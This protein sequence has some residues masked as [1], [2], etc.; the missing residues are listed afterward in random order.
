MSSDALSRDAACFRQAHIANREGRL[1]DAIESLQQA[2]AQAPTNAE[3][4]YTLGRLRKSKGDLEAAEQC[5]REAVRV[6]PE[7]VD[8]W[9][10][11]GILLR[12]AGRPAE[13]EACQREALRIDPKNSLAV[14]NLGNAL[15]SQSKFSDAAEVLRESQGR[16]D[17]A[18]ECF[19]RVIESNPRS[20]EAHNNLGRALLSS[21]EREAAGHFRTALQLDPKLFDAAES[22]GKCQFQIGAFEESVQAFEIAHR[23]R[24][25]SLEIRLLLANAYRAAQMLDKAV[26]EY[27]A[28]LREKPDL[29]KAKGGLATTLADRGQYTKPRALFEQVLADGIEDHLLRLNYAF[30]LLR[31]GDFSN[32]WKYYESRWHAAGKGAEALERGLPVPRWQGEPLTGKRLVMT[33]EQGLGDEMMFASVLP[34]IVAEAEHCIV[35]CDRR[36]E[37]LFRRSFPRATV[38]GVERKGKQWNRALEQNLHALPSFDYWS[39]AGTLVAH[40]RRSAEHFPKH[41]GYLR[42]DAG[43]VQQWKDR[44]STLG[45][46]LKVGISWRGGTALTRIGA[47]SMSLE[48]LRPVLAVSNV[49]FVN[50]QY[51][52]C[53]EDLNAHSAAGGVPIHHWQDAHDDYDETAALVTAL[54]V[55]ISVCTAVV[56]LAGALGRPVWVMAPAV[57]EWRYGHEGPAMIWYP[58]ARIFRQPKQNAWAPVVS[59][60]KR[61]LNGMAARDGR[62]QG[63]GK[64]ENVSLTRFDTRT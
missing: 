52:D 6:R 8:A 5:Y 35:E 17:E 54:D 22:L 41:G 40:R 39:P 21:S 38:F 13:A 30:F 55:V 18:A 3:Y 60:V 10:S 46:G 49:H 45:P 16:F 56:H 31:N 26:A 50:L 34:E 7:Y 59:E 19:R 9:I 51:G 37:S 23:L 32:A 42:A 4:H 2:I 48:L 11:L 62:N 12:N 25:E 33:C 44:L 58:S 63:I 43:R 14:L 24:P 36:L 57:P 1:A 15:L 47:R 29:R 27:E 61:A 53:A 20:A 64:S 28:L